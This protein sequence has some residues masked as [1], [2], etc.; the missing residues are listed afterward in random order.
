MASIIYNLV[1]WTPYFEYLIA[2][3]RRD[4]IRKLYSIG[5][6]LVHIV[7]DICEPI[8]SILYVIWSVRQCRLF[9]GMRYLNFIRHFC[10]PTIT[11]VQEFWKRW[12][13]FYFLK[14]FQ[15]FELF[16]NVLNFFPMFWTFFKFW[17]FFLNFVNLKSEKTK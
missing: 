2:V 14:F 13:F 17:T 7:R 5:I 16:F 8:R 1:N 12:N 4:L 6:G 10:P 3:W 9:Y 15:C 11:L